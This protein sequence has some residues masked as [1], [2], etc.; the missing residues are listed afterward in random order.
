MTKI[1]NIGEL[2]ELIPE[3]RK[4]EGVNFT[5]LKQL[6]ISV[7][8]STEESGNFEFVQYIQGNPS[9]F[10]VRQKAVRSNDRLTNERSTSVPNFQFETSKKGKVKVK[11]PETTPDPYQTEEKSETLISKD[12]DLFPTIKLP[13]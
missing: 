2:Y 10:I 4:L 13:W 1:V 5:N 8:Q 12:T 6:L 9:L 7:I 3:T 11:T